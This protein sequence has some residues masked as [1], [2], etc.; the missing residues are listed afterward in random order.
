MTYYAI[1]FLATLE[2]GVFAEKLPAGAR[3]VRG[4]GRRQREP[5]RDRERCVSRRGDGGWK[6]R[7]S[8]CCRDTQCSDNRACH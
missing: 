4:G 6:H 1:A 7:R 5:E 3:E 2:S 8:V